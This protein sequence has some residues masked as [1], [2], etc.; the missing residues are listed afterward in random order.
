MHN[1]TCQYIGP[2][3]DPVR[4]WPIKMC[5]NP[6]IHGKSYCA[7]HYPKVYMGGSAVTGNCKTA[8]LIEQE[9]R[10]LELAEQIA[11]VE[12]TELEDTNV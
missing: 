12:T 2:E 5:G 6:S 9:L 10:E 8:K 1:H 4:D 11:D 3:Q 7:H